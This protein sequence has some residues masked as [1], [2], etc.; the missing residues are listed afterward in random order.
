MIISV[1]VPDLFA[2][3]RSGTS[4]RGT[5]KREIARV[6]VVVVVA[7]DITLLLRYDLQ[8]TNQRAMNFE[9]ESFWKTLSTDGPRRPW[10]KAQRASCL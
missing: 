5:A 7:W 6:K 4:Q 8:P 9:D 2:L 3:A 1:A 10:E